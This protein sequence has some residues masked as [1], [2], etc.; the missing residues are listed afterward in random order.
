METMYILPGAEPSCLLGLNAVCQLGL[1]C[2]AP[3]VKMHQEDSNEENAEKGGKF[4]SAVVKLVKEERIPQKHGAIL[5]VA[6]FVPSNK[7]MEETA[8]T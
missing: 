5:H 1:V 4:Q 6:M 2:L 7:W 3:E 8:L